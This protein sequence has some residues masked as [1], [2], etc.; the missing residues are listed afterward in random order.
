MIP[1]AISLGFGRL[2]AT[3]IVLVPCIYLILAD[4]ATVFRSKRSSSSGTLAALIK[5][6]AIL[7]GAALGLNVYVLCAEINLRKGSELYALRRKRKRAMLFAFYWA[8]Y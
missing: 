3:I 2:S 5:N 8:F 7:V 4:L 1:M 6:R